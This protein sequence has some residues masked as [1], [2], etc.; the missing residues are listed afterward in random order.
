MRP[1]TR[2][3]QYPLALI[4]KSKYRLRIELSDK[5]DRRK[6]EDV[7][8]PYPLDLSSNLYFCDIYV[9]LNKETDI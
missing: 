9:A 4:E 1:Y 3:Q 8:N 7:L 6:I 2:T 5:F